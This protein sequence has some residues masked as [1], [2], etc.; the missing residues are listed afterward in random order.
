MRLETN[1]T[2]TASRKAVAELLNKVPLSLSHKCLSV[3]R[4]I[5]VTRSM[6]KIAVAE[7]RAVVP[8]P[9][10]RKCLSVPKYIH[11]IRSVSR[12]AFVELRAEVPLSLSRKCG[13]SA[14][15]HPTIAEMRIAPNDV[16]VTRAMSRNT[17]DSK[18]CLQKWKG[19]FSHPDLREHLPKSKIFEG[20]EYLRKGRSLHPYS[21]EKNP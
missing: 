10:S 13:S 11:V 17:V 8:F 9:S 5:C 21:R 7:M 15:P 16:R 6:S 12:K 19:N 3:P 18:T 2:H 1:S 4:Y 14:P 20:R